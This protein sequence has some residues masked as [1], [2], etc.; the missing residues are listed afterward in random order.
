MW[1]VTVYPKGPGYSPHGYGDG[2][3]K[4]EIIAKIIDQFYREVSNENGIRRALCGYEAQDAFEDGEGNPDLGT[5][6]IPDLIYDQNAAGP[7][8][9]TQEFGPRFYRNPPKPLRNA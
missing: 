1:Y 9:G 3:N 5:F 7:G 6:D 8:N 4:P 2:L